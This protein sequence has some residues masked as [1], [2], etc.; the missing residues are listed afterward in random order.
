MPYLIE[1]NSDSSEIS[2]YRKISI[3]GDK[4]KIPNDTL[5]SLLQDENFVVIAPLADLVD[6]RMRNKCT[7]LKV[8]NVN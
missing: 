1:T 6:K 3:R 8:G 5:L 7:I 4:T 2:V